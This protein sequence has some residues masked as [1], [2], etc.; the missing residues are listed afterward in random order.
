MYQHDLLFVN[1]LKIYYIFEN[2]N[3]SLTKYKIFLKYYS[4]VNIYKYIYLSLT[5]Y[6][7][8]YTCNYLYPIYYTSS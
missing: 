7:Y 4:L 5:I 8:I 6:L 1:I 2:K 3:I